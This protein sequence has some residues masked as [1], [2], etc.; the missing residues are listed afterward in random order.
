[1]SVIIIGAGEVGFSLATMFSHEK[2]DVVVIDENEKILRRISD[3]VDAQTLCGHGAS[4]NIL[5]KANVKNSDLVIAVTN[6]DEVNMIAAMTAKHLGVKTTV[7]R[8]RNPDYLRGKRLA[9]RDTL[10][11]DL[12]IN[13][14]MVTATKFAAISRSP[15]AIEIEDYAQGKIKFMHF[16]LD[17]SFI[18]LGME[19]KS[20][21]VPKDFILAAIHRKGE[22][23]IPTGKD[24]LE[25]GD[26]IYIMAKSEK[27]AQVRVIFGTREIQTRKAVI[28]GGGRVGFL[29]AQLLERE[30]IQVRII[31][32]RHDR[33]EILSASLSKTHIIC[34]EGTD[35]SLLREEK[36]DHADL[37]IAVTN[38]DSTNIITCLLAKELGT[39]KVAT[40]VQKADFASFVER[41]GIDV[42]VSPR[43]LTANTIFKYLRTGQI[44]SIAK[45]IEGKAEVLEI[46]AADHCKACSRPIKNLH[47]PNGAIIGALQKHDSIIIPRGNDVIDP[48]DH[49]IV[50]ALPHV[51][52]EIDRFFSRTR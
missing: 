21:P 7:A 6:I 17:D 14:A 47:F 30:G 44:V 42:G 10:G 41:F 49:V 29:T 19:L 48:G 4:I 13:P 27:A 11:I 36:I 28:I 33:C 26:T 1:M 38:D 15:G 22:L 46:I 39:P 51:V 24:S 32:K 9:Y 25:E 45:L 18:Y 37:L 35:V 50:L 5:E 43:L 3:N 34:G 12:V 20:F 23:I 31:E 16:N 52:N 40:L 2:R 8:V